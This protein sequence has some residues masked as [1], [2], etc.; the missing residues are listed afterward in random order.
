MATL[1]NIIIVYNG[2]T[3]FAAT[4]SDHIQCG[5]E[6]IEIASPDTGQWADFIAGRKKWSL[7]VDYLVSQMQDLL[8]VGTVYTLKIQIDRYN[9]VSGK[10]LLETC[11]IQSSVGNLAKGSFKFQGKGALSG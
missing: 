2:D 6:K 1:G 10:A 4:K 7:T 3:P 8:N 9:Y 11:D 5:C